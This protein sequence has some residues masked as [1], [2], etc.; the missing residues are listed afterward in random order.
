MTTLQSLYLKL[1]YSSLQTSANGLNRQQQV[2]RMTD[3]KGQT[4]SPF[5]MSKVKSRPE[6]LVAGCSMPALQ[7]PERCG[8]Q[9]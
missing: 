7:P 3:K 5:G 2:S 9:G 1:L 6:F 8:R 4:W